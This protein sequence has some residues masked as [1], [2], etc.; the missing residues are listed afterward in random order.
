MR[1]VVRKAYE[2]CVVEAHATAWAVTH[3]MDVQGQGLVPPTALSSHPASLVHEMA[4][5]NGVRRSRDRSADRRT[6]EIL[7]LGIGDA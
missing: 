5:G 4:D 6:G 1:A 2:G 3:G 7:A